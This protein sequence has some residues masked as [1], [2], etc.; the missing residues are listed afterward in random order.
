M[1]NVQL[2]D[3]YLSFSLG[4][5]SLVQILSLLNAM[6]DAT[7]IKASQEQQKEQRIKIWN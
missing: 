3:K 2:V 7:Y 6:P 1:L 4:I 5:W